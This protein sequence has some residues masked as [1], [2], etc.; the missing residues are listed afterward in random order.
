MS[1]AH[2]GQQE[3]LEAVAA[4]IRAVID[5]EWVEDVE[6]GMDTNFAADLEIE[7]VEMVALAERLQT[8]YGDGLDLARWLADKEMDDIFALTVGDLVRFIAAGT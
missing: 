4:D 1:A 8:R 5:E 3:I 7:S 2:A 6:I